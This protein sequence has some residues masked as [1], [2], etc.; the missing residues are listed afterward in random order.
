MDILL[1]GYYTR[2]SCSLVKWNSQRAIITMLPST[3]YPIFSAPLGWPKL[4]IIFP[5]SPFP[6]PCNH[7]VWN[8]TKFWSFFWLTLNLKTKSKTRM[9]SAHK[10]V[11]APKFST[12]VSFVEN[13]MEPPLPPKTSVSR[14]IFFCLFSPN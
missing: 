5:Q 9:I 4:T 10:R 6:D 12:A 11:T 7:L 8:S 13:N 3:P 1:L 2:F 14:R